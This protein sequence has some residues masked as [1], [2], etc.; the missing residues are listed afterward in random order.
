M[1]ALGKHALAPTATNPLNGFYGFVKNSTHHADRASHCYVAKWDDTLGRSNVTA[2]ET[3]S[4]S[5][6]T[7]TGTLGP[8]NVTGAPG[9]LI[10]VILF[11]SAL[12]MAPSCG[13][14]A[15]FF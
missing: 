14:R 5:N 7:T 12:A 1:A 2:T 6:V 13:G 3:L 11:G 9:P 15:S 8:S 10:A 4:R